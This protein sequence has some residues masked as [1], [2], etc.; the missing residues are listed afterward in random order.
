MTEPLR[1]AHAGEL[2]LDKTSERLRQL[3][4]ARRKAERQIERLVEAFTAEVITLDEL[5]ARRAGLQERVRVLMQQEREG[6][7]HQRQQVRLTDLSA[8]MTALCRAVRRGLHTLDFAGQ[9]SVIEIL[10][11]RVLIDHDGI[12]IRYAAPLTGWNPSG[13]K[14]SLRLPLR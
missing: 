5:K 3:Q 1:K 13:K 2:W 10:V 7:S 11:D 6:Q 12:E 9:R 8:N 4:Q 14:P